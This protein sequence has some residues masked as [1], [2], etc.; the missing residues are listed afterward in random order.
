MKKSA[1]LKKILVSAFTIMAVFVACAPFQDSI[2]SDTLLRKERHLNQKMIATLPDVDSD[3][4]IRIA[5]LADSHQNYKPLDSTIDQVNSTAGI[6]FVAN[7]GDFTNSAYN[8]EYD[9]FLK[10]YARIEFPR[11]TTIGNHDAIGAGPS[12]F[13]KAFGDINFWFESSSH[14]FVFFSTANLEDPE[15]FD[16]NWLL[17]V[18]NASAKPVI[19]FTHIALEDPERFS[20]EV[21][22]IFTQVIQKAQLIL[23]GHNH[24]YLSRTLLGT[25]L[26]HGPRVEVG[27]MILEIQGTSLKVIQMPQGQVEWFTLKP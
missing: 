19:I 9:Q 8:L 17:H 6:D 22:P 23:N 10:S 1:R 18:V 26:I 21:A 25:P 5:V 2:F 3:G 24:V 7:L 20:G 14:R 12:L 11:L 27:W 4:V 13:K 15:S 16:P